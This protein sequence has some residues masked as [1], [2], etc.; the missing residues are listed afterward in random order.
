MK[1]KLPKINIDRADIQAF[2]KTDNGILLISMGISLL[3]WFLI[4]LSQDYKANREVTITYTLPADMSYIT[5]P[6]KKVRVTLS[7]TGWDLM[8]DFFGGRNS[9][10]NFNLASLPSQTITNNQLKGKMVENA[11]SSNVTVEDMSFDY[12]TVELGESATKKIP[13]VLEQQLSF[14]PEHQ[15]QSPIEILPDSIIISGPSALLV[16]YDSWPTTLLVLENLKSSVSRPL[17]LEPNTKSQIALSASSVQIKIPIEQFTEKSIFLPVTIKNAPD[18]LKVFP[19]K[20]KTSFVVGLSKYDAISEKD[21]QLEVDLKGIPINQANNTAPIS[22]TKQPSEV[23]NIRF[24]PKS[25][26]FLFVKE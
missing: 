2:L 7:G 9:Q 8:Y 22:L 6:P 3:F 14:A 26:Q 23:K 16:D 5:I 11:Q 25:V 4:K 18:S 21:F 12:I 19:N 10:L 17:T 24:S 1:F 20:V 13:V 15:L